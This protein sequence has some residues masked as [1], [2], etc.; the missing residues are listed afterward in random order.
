MIRI[1]LELDVYFK[2]AKNSFIKFKTVMSSIFHMLL[3]KKYDP[4]CLFIMKNW[5]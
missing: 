3:P 2:H 1:V 5:M 4:H